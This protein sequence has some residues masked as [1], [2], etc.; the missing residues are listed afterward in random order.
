MRPPHTAKRG[1]FLRVSDP[2][3]HSIDQLG[4]HGLIDRVRIKSGLPP[5]GI[6]LGI[7]DDAAVIASE[8]GA[9]DV[10]TTDS[11]IEGVHFNRAWTGARAIG[12]KALAV[13]LSD[14]AAMGA[15]PRAS[16]LSLALPKHFSVADFDALVDGYLDLA[17]AEGATLVGG[18]LTMS[19]GPVMVSVTAIGAARPR[20]VLTRAGARPG[21]ELYVTGT[22]GGAAAGLSILR[23][24]RDRASLNQAELDAVDRYERPLARGRCG[25]IVAKTGGA[26]AAIDLSD[27]LGDAARQL[28]QASGVGVILEG[29]MV[30]VHPAAQGVGGVNPLDLALCGGEDYELAFAVSAR[31]RSRFLAAIRRCGDINVTRVGRFVEGTGAWLETD[32]GRHVLPTGFEHFTA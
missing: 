5:A 6:V 13:N 21:D 20:R 12:H 25:R 9:H 32:A 1:S 11:L 31:R 26:N 28:M 2:R 7:G 8:R 16:L 23:N 17:R 4:E 24:G 3:T 10:V 22:L 19:P 15:T 18:N 29:V 30:P 27:G 14:L